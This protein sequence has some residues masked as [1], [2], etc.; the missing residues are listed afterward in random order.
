MATTSEN[1]ALGV[2]VEKSRADARG[3]SAK[4]VGTDGWFDV[5]DGQT[6]VEVKSAEKDV[7]VNW[8]DSG[9]TRPGRYQLDEDNHNNLVDHGGEYDFVLRDGKDTVAE[10]TMTAA[11]VDDLIDELDRKWPTGSKLK[12]SWKDV[13]PEVDG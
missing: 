6:P 10:R 9:R 3:P 7:T 1:R 4:H 12:L 5:E 8:D 13:H 2:Q 11:E